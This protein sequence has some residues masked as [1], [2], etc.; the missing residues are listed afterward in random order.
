MV[1]KKGRIQDGGITEGR[2]VLIS[3]G[4]LTRGRGNYIPKEMRGGP[5]EMGD[6]PT[7]SLVCRGGKKRRLLR[8]SDGMGGGDSRQF[9][10]KRTFRMGRQ[11]EKRINKNKGNPEKPRRNLSG[12]KNPIKTRALFYDEQREAKK[13]ILLKSANR[14]SWGSL[15][16]EQRKTP[17]KSCNSAKGRGDFEKSGKD[18]GEHDRLLKRKRGF[19][20][21]STKRS[22]GGEKTPYRAVW[23]GSRQIFERIERT[24]SMPSSINGGIKRTKVNCLRWL[25][26]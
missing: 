1:G 25:R 4:W 16:S 5:V 18:P 8:S 12:R 6:A 10:R 9:L 26:T 15:V 21:T 2:Q 22:R 20:S 24:Q 23:V 11:L 13:E 19:K 7:G 17:T 14:K 3:L